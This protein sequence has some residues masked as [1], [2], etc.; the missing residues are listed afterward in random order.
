MTHNGLKRNGDEFI[1]VFLFAG[2]LDIALGIAFLA[3]PLPPAGIQDIDTHAAV[4]TT[5]IAPVSPVI[6]FLLL[7]SGITLIVTAAT[8]RRK[9]GQPSHAGGLRNEETAR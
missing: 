5:R 7:A 6:S 8:R 9:P 3:A 4:Q 2:L 1:R